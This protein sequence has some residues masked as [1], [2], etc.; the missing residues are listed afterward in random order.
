MALV[1]KA[2]YL[3]LDAPV[4]NLDFKYQLAV[5]DLLKSL[6]ESGI[7]VIVVLHDLN[8]IDLVSDNVVLLSKENKVVHAQGTPL[9]ILTEDTLEQVFSVRVKISTVEQRRS[10]HLLGY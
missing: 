7:S 2:D 10:F 8:L 6:K 1:Q 4:S 9:E 5:A 3:I